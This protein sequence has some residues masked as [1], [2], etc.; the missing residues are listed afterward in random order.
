[1]VVFIVCNRC[2]MMHDLCYN[3]AEC[4]MMME[5]VQPYYWKC[6]RGYKPV[7]GKMLESSFFTFKLM[8]NIFC[9]SC[10]AWKVG[11]IGFVRPEVVRVWSQFLRVP[12]EVSL[13]EEQSHVHELAVATCTKSFY[14]FLKEFKYWLCEKNARVHPE[15]RYIYFLRKTKLMPSTLYKRYI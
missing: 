14:G 12:E 4:P 10:W 3:A 15:Y 5:Y 9:R 7:C 8:Q 1:M 2:C 6:Y 13:P 11:R